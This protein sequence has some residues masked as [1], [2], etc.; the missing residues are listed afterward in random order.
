M[1]L[2]NVIIQPLLTEKGQSLQEQQNQVLFRVAMNA[3]KIEIRKAVERLFDVKVLSVRTQVVRGKNSRQR[4]IQGK[5]A[6]WKKAIVS[7]ADGESI[8][9]FEGI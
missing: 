1:N 9:F 3:N 2:Q 5:K 4:Q 6:N 7:L 8:E